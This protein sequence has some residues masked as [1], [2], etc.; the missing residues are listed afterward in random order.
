M[1][2]YTEPGRKSSTRLLLRKNLKS[3]K[4]KFLIHFFPQILFDCEVSGCMQTAAIVWVP[5]CATLTPS[6]LEAL[7]FSSFA[8]HS[9]SKLG[10]Q[11]EMSLLLLEGSRKPCCDSPRSTFHTS[12]TLFNIWDKLIRSIATCGLSPGGL[13]A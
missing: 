6:S 10:E 4:Y 13:N 12:E 9:G 8:V 11:E 7:F 3:R 5:G 2:H 1:Q